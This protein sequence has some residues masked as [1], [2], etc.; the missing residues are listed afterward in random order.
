MPQGATMAETIRHGP[1]R[2]R[3]NE[4]KQM[5]TN[6]KQTRENE[7]QGRN[8]TIRI[9]VACLAAYNNGQLHGEWIDAAQDADDI[10]AAV[11]EMLKKSPQPAAEE[12]A[13]HDYEGFG[14]IKLSESESFDTVAA[15]A[16]AI[17][18]HGELFAHYYGHA[19]DGDDI[20]TVVSNFEENYRGAFDS[21]A[22]H[23]QEF[24]EECGEWKEDD[25]AGFWHPSKYVDWERMAHD[26][27]ISGDVFTI[28]LDGKVHVYESNRFD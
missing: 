15:L 28:E 3:S 16:A 12:W 4:R 11:A 25:K 20:E 21:L 2:I 13:I 17:E 27:E 22:D 7:K 6:E 19:A 9:Y 26:L 1:E 10:K 23:V 18:E 5:N 8:S 24:W 14:P